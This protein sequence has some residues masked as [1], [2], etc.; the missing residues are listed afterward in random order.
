MWY[1][2]VRNCVCV[3]LYGIFA[4]AKVIHQFDVKYGFNN[5]KLGV[6]IGNESSCTFEPFRNFYFGFVFCFV[7]FAALS[8]NRTRKKQQNHFHSRCLCLQISICMMYEC[9]CVYFRLVYVLVC[10]RFFFALIHFLSYL[11][12]Y[13]WI[14]LHLILIHIFFVLFHFCTHTHISILI[15]A[16]NTVKI[17]IPMEKNTVEHSIVVCI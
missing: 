17:L 10:A 7:L 3:C 2:W 8:K 9:F 16:A 6:Y 14:H 1:V 13:I 5:S 15:C 11:L 12:S 4:R